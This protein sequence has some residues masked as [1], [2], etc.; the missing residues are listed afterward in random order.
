MNSYTLLFYQEKNV[1]MFSLPPGWQSILVEPGS[2][3]HNFVVQTGLN[4][5]AHPE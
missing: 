1:S 2:G 5:P 4:R 3:T